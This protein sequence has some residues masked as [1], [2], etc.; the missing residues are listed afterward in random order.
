MDNS[1]LSFEVIFVSSAPR[2][3]ILPGV[4]VLQ[5]KNVQKSCFWS[6]LFVVE[7]GIFNFQF[8]QIK[9]KVLPRF[10]FL[11]LAK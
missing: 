4:L 6:L 5:A 7:D 2:K 9:S 8:L 10:L 3:S 1:L 11:A